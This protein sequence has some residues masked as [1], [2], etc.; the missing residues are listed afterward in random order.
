[1]S[2][3]KVQEKYLKKHP[4]SEWRFELKMR[5]FPL[6]VQDLYEKDNVTFVFFFDQVIF[7]VKIK[8]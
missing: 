4:L 7:V 6:S 8:H 1:M 5:Y 2:M 3:A